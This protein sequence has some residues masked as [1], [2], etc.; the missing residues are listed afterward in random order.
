MN[1]PIE[2]FIINFL[3]RK[4]SPGDVEKLKEWLA[5][6]PERRTE[7]KQWLA[8]WDSAGMMDATE[9]FDPEKAYQ[10]FMFRLG[11]ETITKTVPKKFRMDTDVFK[12]ILRIAAIFVISFSSG[13]LCHY[14]WAK[15]DIEQVAFIENNVTRG[16]KSEIRL[17][18]GSTVW[19]N[20][21][22][23]LRYPTSYGKTKRDIYLSGEGYF[24]V[25]HQSG[26]P[27]TVHTALANIT[28][29]GTMFNVKAYP[30]ENVEEM[31]VINGE[32]AVE[33]GES[34]NAFDRTILKPGQK[35]SVT[36]SERQLSLAITSIDPNMA[37]AE[38]SWK[39][40]TLRF[41]SEPL[42]TVAIKLERRYNVHITVDDR[43]KNLRFTGTLEDETLQQVLNIIQ[44]S[45]PVQFHIEGDN[46]NIFD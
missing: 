34:A 4:E 11:S 20:T 16:S 5:S 28:A 9:K 23:T 36:L 19:L 17:P 14:Y 18:D 1:N 7:L 6:D 42:Q 8:V 26:K 38:V 39:D 33:N 32:L 24:S 22:S 31:I 13:M 12:T 3:A 41:D 46:V 30:D 37:E 25:I 44:H 29:L 10:R 45:L 27:F 2:D 35:L 40:D 43:L 15:D 21:G